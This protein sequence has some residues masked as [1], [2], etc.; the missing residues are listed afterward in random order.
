L[1]ETLRSVDDASNVILLGP[2]GVGK[3]HLTVALAV[4][5]VHAGFG[6]FFSTANDLVTDLGRAY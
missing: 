6:A 5:A 1:D 4:D 3:T 2:P